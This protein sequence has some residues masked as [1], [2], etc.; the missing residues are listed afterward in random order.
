ML[1]LRPVSSLHTYKFVLCF[2][3]AACGCTG[4]PLLLVVHLH[5]L[6]SLVWAVLGAAWGCVLTQPGFAGTY[7]HTCPSPAQRFGVR[8]YPGTHPLGGVCAKLLSVPVQS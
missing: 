3:S 2:T 1:L 4:S 5:P 7:R 8:L 6:S